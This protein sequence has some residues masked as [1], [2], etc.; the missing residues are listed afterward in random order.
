MINQIDKGILNIDYNFLN[1][2]KK[3]TFNQ[4]YIIRNS[5]GTTEERNVRTNY[6]YRADGTKLRKAYTSYFKNQTE[7]TTTTDY[8]DGFQY[9]VNYLNA[10]MLEFIPTAEG[11]FNFKDNT[12]IYNYTDHLGNVRL[13]YFNN[14]TSAE[15]LEENNYYPFGL[16]HQG[17]NANGGNPAYKYQY[18]GKELQEE[19][20]M[21]DYGARFY[22]PDIG[23]W[24]VID[25]LAEKYRRWSPY[26]YVMNNTIRFI[27]PDGRQPEWIVGKDGKAV[28]YKQNKDGSLIWSKNATA[29][30]KRI[31]DEMAKTKTGLSRLNKMRDAKHG[32][33]I[34][35][36]KTAK[37]AGNWAETT[38]P[39][40]L[41]RNE[42]TGEVTSNY[43]KI[44]FF[45]A[46]IEKRMEEHK[47]APEGTKFIGANYNELYDLWTN[48]GM[49]AV[50]GSIGVHE[51]N[52]ATDPAN[53]KLLGENIA[54]GKNNDLEK[55]P[56]AEEG[57][58]LKELNE[59]KQK[60]ET[61]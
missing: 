38:H 61:N 59:K 58:H 3:L 49:S 15:V 34:E 51:G 7:R 39:K 18:N 35:I 50:L 14:G 9:T 27:D 40:K 29:D 47:A 60:N 41:G 2:P 32:V 37:D 52:H 4:A 57:K 21:Y 24:G 44:E 46:R 19:T 17:Y 25:P 43:A 26:N 36:N 11:Y 6:S 20:G 30:T 28:T 16:K 8:L 10:A 22:M 45:E 48:E 1:L 42:K 12:Y 56:D 55:G 13:S 54:K 23:R 31:G 5:N 33:E 53:L